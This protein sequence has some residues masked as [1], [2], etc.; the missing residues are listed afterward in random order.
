MSRYLIPLVFGA[1]YFA[2]AIALS[3]LVGVGFEGVVE[4][5]TH[6]PWRVASDPY[7]FCKTV[8][9]LVSMF[10]L[11]DYAVSGARTLGRALYNARH[12]RSLEDE[13]A[14][15]DDALKTD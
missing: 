3:W 13:L 15:V 5:F 4:E 8:S 9:F 7:F 1:A 2:I 10:L 6:A 11:L 12:A 14:D